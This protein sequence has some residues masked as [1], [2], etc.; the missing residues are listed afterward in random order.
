MCGVEA[1]KAGPCVLAVF[2]CFP[3]PVVSGTQRRIAGNLDLLQRLGCT[4]HVLYYVNDEQTADSIEESSMRGLCVESI[5]AGSRREQHEFGNWSL[6]LHK[7]DFFVR[8]ALETKGRRYP[9]SMRYDAVGACRRILREAHRVNANIVI[10]P[11]IFMHYADRLTAEGFRVI[12]DAYDVLSEIT[13]SILDG[14]RDERWWKRFSLYANYLA[15]RA[16][17]R[18]FF[19]RCDE[20]WATSDSEAESLA[21]FAPGARILVVPSSLDERVVRPSGQASVGE[22]VG[23]IGLYSFQP[24]L[25]AVLFL[26]EQVFPFVI[27]R[28]PQARLRLAGAGL[29]AEARKRLDRI[30]NIDLLGLVPDSGKFI[31]ECAVIAL[32]ILVR[33]GV[34]VKLIESMARGKAVVVRPEIVGGLPVQDGKDLIIREDP[35]EF[36]DAVLSLLTHPEESAR[37]GENARR[38]FLDN[39]STESALKNMRQKSIIWKWGGKKHQDYA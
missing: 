8:G 26:A 36:A 12:A 2:T 23:F 39:W 29:P 9:F 27:A 15:C 22:Y 10:L 20:I 33:G 37:L 17:E 3:F 30:P 35:R 24:N 16:Q 32:P 4:N 11:S 21:R 31:D 34:P 25:E 7:L 28:Q 5:C 18:I 1:E 38:T 19:P 13:A 14:H 6:A